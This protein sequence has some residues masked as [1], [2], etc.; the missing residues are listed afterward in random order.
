MID[1]FEDI[2]EKEI[3]VSEGHVYVIGDDWFRSAMRGLLPNE[4]I[5]G[6]VLGYR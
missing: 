3:N 1:Y 6:K 2:N 4:N 5:M